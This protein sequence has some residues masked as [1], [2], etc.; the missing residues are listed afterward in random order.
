MTNQKFKEWKELV[1]Q[2]KVIK[3]KEQELRRELCG[4]MFAGR[5]GEFSVERHMDEYK[6]I[7]KSRV[8]RTIDETVLES[9]EEDLTPQE[10]GCI[11]RKPT[12]ILAN[13]RKL[14]EDS[15]LFEAVTEKPA[16]PS[17]SLVDL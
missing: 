2:L 9:I 7:A 5:E 6:A 14:P 13:Y 3:Q 12:V 16:M 10:L 15:L 1:N 4:D 17:L 11:K 8:T